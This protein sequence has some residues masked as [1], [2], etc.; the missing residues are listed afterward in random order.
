[1]TIDSVTLL[2]PVYKLTIHPSSDNQQLV[3]HRWSSSSVYSTIPSRRF[4]DDST[5]MSFTEICAIPPYP[6]VIW[7]HWL[8]D[9]TG[10]RHTI[11]QPHSQE[12]ISGTVLW[13]CRLGGRKGIRSVKTEWWGAGVVTCLERGA[14]L[15]MAQLMPLPLT[16]S[17]FSKIQIGFIFLIPVHLGSH[18]KR[19]IKRVC[20]ISGTDED[21]QKGY[22]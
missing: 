12:I 20:V 11:N 1:M 6:L 5:Y 8:S 18:G 15:H 10:N 19:A 4:T 17:R 14:D 13:R 9:G 22:S 16:V 3:Y 2:H 21:N 7:Q